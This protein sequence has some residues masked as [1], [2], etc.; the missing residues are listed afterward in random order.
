[1]PH[2]RLLRSLFAIV[3]ASLALAACAG[4]PAAPARPDC[5]ASGVALTVGAGTTPAF[6]WT[7][8]CRVSALRVQTA[9]GDTV[10]WE[11]GRDDERLD[12][13][14]QYGTV[15]PGAAERA[16]ARPLAAGRAYRVVL[17]Q[18]VGVGRVLATQP[19]TP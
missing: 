2:A 17:V 8:Q 1:M 18:Q 14:L 16:P 11:V 3:L 5:P 15:P 6:S 7:P 19:F 12:A 13:P 10:Y 4:D 9:V